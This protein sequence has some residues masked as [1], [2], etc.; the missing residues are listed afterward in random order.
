MI[1][2][3]AFLAFFVLM[4]LG[5]L[6]VAMRG[7]PK[8]IAAGAGPQSR[9]SRRA[10]NVALPI[11]LVVT[12]LGIPYWILAA[13]SSGHDKRGVAGVELNDSQA[14]GRLLFAQNC[15]TCHTLRGA[16]AVAKVGPNLDQLQAVQNEAFVLDAI[17][18]GRAQG[19]GQMPPAL[20]DGAD[21]RDVA[22]FVRAVAGR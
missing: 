6:A 4:G 13:N 22:S 18:N 14:R 20:L 21:A 5:V 17:R 2:A 10:W 8:A 11:V 9:A 12:G 19:R 1:A 3:I 7:G 15:S 16:N